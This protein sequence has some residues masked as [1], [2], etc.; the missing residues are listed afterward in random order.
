MTEF[1]YLDF[2]EQVDLFDSRNMNIKDKKKA[3]VKLQHINYYKIKEFAE[4]FCT[5]LENGELDYCGVQFDFIIGRYYQDKYLRM[6]LFHAIEKIEVSIK[7]NFSDILGKEA[8][9]YGYL[10]F[11]K[12]CDKEKYCKYYLE[13]KEKAFK[14]RLNNYLTY[15]SNREI[16][17]KIKEIKQR[18]KEKFPPV[19]LAVNILMFGDL[20]HLVELMSKSKLK[21]LASRYGDI[22]PAQF[23]SWLKTLQ[24]V[25][26]LCAHNENIV[27]LKLKTKPKIHESCFRVVLF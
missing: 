13:D 27:D 22:T 9:A 1:K 17:R 4:P 23:I 7:S 20:I 18:G 5:K 26:N 25:R 2:N 16:M 12:W 3:A 10:E 21:K 15:T 8:G 11:S 14:K 6:N 19:W 24:L